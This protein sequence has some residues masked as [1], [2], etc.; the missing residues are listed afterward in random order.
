MMATN[1]RPEDGFPVRP[2]VKHLYI[3][4]DDH[5]V[6]VRLGIVAERLEPD[7]QQKTLRSAT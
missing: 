6:P 4:P 5:H 7:A 3:L 1:M 2:D